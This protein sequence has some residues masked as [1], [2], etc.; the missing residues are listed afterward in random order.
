MV[1]AVKIPV[2]ANGDIDSGPSA[3]RAL[4]E[5]GAAAVMIGR[6]ALGNPWVFA[7][8]RAAMESAAPPPA[9]T[10]EDRLSTAARQTE[11]AA[12]YKGE[13]IAMLEAR[14]HLA[15]YLKG[16][17]NTAKYRARFSLGLP[18]GKCT[19]SWTKSG[20]R[21]RERKEEHVA[22]E[23]VERLKS[24]D[25]GAFEALVHACE[26]RVYNLALRYS[27]NHADAMDI[28]QEVFLRVLRSVDKF[29][30]ECSVET[31]V[32]RIAV[33]LSID[34][35]RRRTRRGE[36]SLTVGEDEETETQHDLPDDTYA[37]EPAYDRTEL[38]ES[39]ARAVAALPEEHRKILVLRDIDGF[40]YAQISEILNLEEGTVKSRLFRARARLRETLSGGGNFSC[41]SAS[42]GQKGGMKRG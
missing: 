4:A 7:Q 35:T 1:Q 23:L 22:D 31:W 8:V 24:G 32:Y 40:T 19:R 2:I 3:L 21:L 38:R 12:A 30:G 14:R 10:L 39:V 20:G 13:Y 27:N 15:W 5:T 42:K 25:A 34:H 16:L 17:P 37:P 41:L 18:A 11:L 33:N 28:S 6:G 29:K 36:L 9:P 26:R